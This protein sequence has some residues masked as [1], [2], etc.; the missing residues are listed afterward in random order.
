MDQQQSLVATNTSLI[1]SPTQAVAEIKQ[2]RDVVIAIMDQVMKPGIHYG[3]LPGVPRPFLTKDG[4]EVLCQAFRLTPREELV[5]DLGSEIEAKYRVT[6][7][8]Y[9]QL[10]ERVG[11]GMGVCSSLEEKNRWRKA[12]KSTFDDTPADLRRMETKPSK[13]GPGTYTL[14]QVQSSRADMD[15]TCLQQALKRAYVQATRQ[16]LAVSDLFHAI[17]VGDMSEAEKAALSISAPR[18]V[19]MPK[20]KGPSKQATA[21]KP[22]PAKAAPKQEQVATVQT[23]P[24]WMND[25]SDPGPAGEPVEPSIKDDPDM[26]FFALADWEAVKNKWHDRG[27]IS[28]AQEG[29]LFA[30]AK[31]HGWDEQAVRDE[32]AKGLVGAAVSEIP[33]GDSYNLT[34]ALFESQER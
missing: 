9:N 5:E 32:I 29:R 22:A 26:P 11:F 34:V 13:D 10:N 27:T 33:W 15:N 6:I 19:G 30:I 31:K 7:G 28:A 1:L 12:D 20:S 17:D 24:E 23:E 2:T 25:P 16:R 14:Y 18:K 21:P 8:L 3:T 4:A